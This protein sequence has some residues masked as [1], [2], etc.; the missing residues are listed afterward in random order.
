MCMLNNVGVI[1]IA[2]AVIVTF[3][4]VK[5]YY[6]SIEEMKS[7]NQGSFLFAKFTTSTMRKGRQLGAY[8]EVK[9]MIG[10]RNDRNS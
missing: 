10:S 6:Y 4:K 3:I 7:S 5:N 9:A 1:A 2:L 8:K